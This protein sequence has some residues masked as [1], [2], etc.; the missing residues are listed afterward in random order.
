MRFDLGDL[1]AEGMPCA[2]SVL[3][4][5]SAALAPADCLSLAPQLLQ[6]LSTGSTCEPHRMQ[7]I[8]KASLLHLSQYWTNLS[9]S[10]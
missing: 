8:N 6:K 5:S 10:W 2:R 9:I 1:A 7:T 4:L 3:E